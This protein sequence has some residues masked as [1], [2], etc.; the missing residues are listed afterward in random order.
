VVVGLL[1]FFSGTGSFGHSI[2]TDLV[3][4]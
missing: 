3:F 2:P 4:C 1:L